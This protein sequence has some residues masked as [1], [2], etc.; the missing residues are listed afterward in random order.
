MMLGEKKKSFNEVY[1]K[2]SNENFHKLEI[3]INK[4]LENTEF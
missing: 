3:G 2:L 4:A 1:E